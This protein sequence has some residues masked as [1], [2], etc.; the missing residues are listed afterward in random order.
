MREVTEGSK[1]GVAAEGE[2]GEGGQGTWVVVHLYQD[3]CV[4]A[5]LGNK[6]VVGRLIIWKEALDLTTTNQRATPPHAP[7]AL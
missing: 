1:A 2:E 7:L 3:R 4:R 5:C 6:V